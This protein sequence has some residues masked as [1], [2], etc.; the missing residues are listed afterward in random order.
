M[1]V[2]QGLALITTMLVVLLCSCGCL[3][4]HVFSELVK[5]FWR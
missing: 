1:V 5:Y 3:V 2:R 4:I